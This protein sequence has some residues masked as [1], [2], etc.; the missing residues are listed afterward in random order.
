M[1]A[2]KA[3][4]PE[5]AATAAPR[6]RGT[7]RTGA[8]THDQIAERAYYLH[9]D[10]PAGDEVERWLRAE[11]ELGEELLRAERSPGRV[12]RAK[13]GAAPR[14]AKASKAS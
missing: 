13:T 10:E 3:P 5:A 12:S 14:S 4:M 7:R 6:R 1:P 9:L 2:T 8:P 11:R